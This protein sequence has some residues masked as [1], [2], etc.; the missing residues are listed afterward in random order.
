MKLSDFV[1]HTLAEIKAGVG[2]ANEAG[3]RCQM[4][5]E[6]EFEVPALGPV[7]LSTDDMIVW[8]EEIEPGRVRFVV[9]VSL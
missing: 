3:T 8:H 5:K 9:R 6:V 4:P 1:N 2:Q 7:V